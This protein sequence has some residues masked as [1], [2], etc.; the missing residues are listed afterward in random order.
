MLLPSQ[1]YQL[2]QQFGFKS[3]YS[4]QQQAVSRFMQYVGKLLSLSFFISVPIWNLFGFWHSITLS[5]VLQ[6]AMTYVHCMTVVTRV[7]LKVLSIFRKSAKSL[8]AFCVVLHRYCWFSH[9]GGFFFA[10]SF[11]FNLHLLLRLSTSLICSL[12]S[13]GNCEKH[14]NCL[15]LVDNKFSLCCNM[16]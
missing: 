8:D 15:Y 11:F 14:P 5:C 2:A 7:N 9:P 1:Q 13:V 4:W 10:K 6:G 12:V 3:L 16:I